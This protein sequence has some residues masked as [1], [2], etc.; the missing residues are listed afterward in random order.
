MTNTYWKIATVLGVAVD[1]AKNRREPHLILR[2]DTPPAFE[3][4]FGCNWLRGR[5]EIET[6][7]LFFANV[8]TPRIACPPDLDDLEGRLAA[9]LEQEVRRHI[10]GSTLALFNAGGEPVLTARA[11][12]LR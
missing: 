9:A 8:A 12:Y 4:T 6:G 1:A 11:T 10:N 7:S 2:S 5:Y 3:A